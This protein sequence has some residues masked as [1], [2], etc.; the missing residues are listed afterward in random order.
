MPGP[1][2][3]CQ[4]ALG[5]RPLPPVRLHCGIKVTTMITVGRRRAPDRPGIQPY[6]VC[7][8]P[9]ATSIRD[10]WLYAARAGVLVL[11]Q[12]VCTHHGIIGMKGRQK[13]HRLIASPVCNRPHPPQNK[14]QSSSLTFL[15]GFLA[16]SLACVTSAGAAWIAT[17]R[18]TR[19]AVG[20]PCNA[21]RLTRAQH[22]RTL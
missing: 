8:S 16:G 15:H 9:S 18:D 14:N 5:I 1:G 19:E 21:R 11:A 12:A 6:V 10:L 13:R 22:H 4:R 3:P 17:A 7:V 20:H 2:R